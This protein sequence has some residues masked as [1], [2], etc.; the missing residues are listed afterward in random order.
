MTTS[1]NNKNMDIDLTNEANNNNNNG[2]GKDFSE[3]SGGAKNK[4][5]NGRGGNNGG[6]NTIPTVPPL[7][8]KS[9]PERLQE[10]FIPEESKMRTTKELP[11]SILHHPYY[12]IASIFEKE[13][14]DLAVLTIASGNKGQTV[15]LQNFH[16]L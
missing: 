10:D 8:L 3:D 11:Q 15:L 13:Y 4:G 14:K 7:K 1:N 9:W 16:S 12:Q 5:S 6:G 2:G